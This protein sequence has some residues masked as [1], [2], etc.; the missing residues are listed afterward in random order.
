MFRSD[1]VNPLHV[2]QVSGLWSRRRAL[3]LGLLG[4]V[5]LAAGCGL[6]PMYAPGGEESS[7]PEL[8]LI[9]VETIPTRA[10]QILRNDLL[11]R[12]TPEGEPATPRYKLRVKVETRSVSLAIQPDAS[13]T[14]FNLLLKVRFELSDVATGEI[15]YRDKL[16]SVGSYNAVRSDFATLI[17]EQDTSRRS[18]VSASEEIVALLAVFFARRPGTDD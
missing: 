4:G 18:A 5:A 17:A 13:I 9:R 6:R 14:R 1:R 8:A 2:L 11:D 16:R 12:L 15:I 10:G 7:V 3:R